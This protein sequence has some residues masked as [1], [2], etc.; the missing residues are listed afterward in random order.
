MG[1][2][3]TVRMFKDGRTIKVN[4]DCTLSYAREGWSRTDPNEPTG[5][6][7]K[8]LTPDEITAENMIKEQLLKDKPEPAPAQEGLDLSDL[9]VD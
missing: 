8:E 9:Q 5:K 6:V 4:A 7:K 1:W 3:P 2:I